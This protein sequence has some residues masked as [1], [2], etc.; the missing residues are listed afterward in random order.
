MEIKGLKK[1][2]Q[3]QHFLKTAKTDEVAVGTT[4]SPMTI[5]E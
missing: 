4:P 5:K 1:P 3:N 2:T